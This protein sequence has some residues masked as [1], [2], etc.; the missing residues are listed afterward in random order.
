MY[1]ENLKY[2]KEHLWAR[3]EGGTAYIGITDFAQQQLGEIL[4]VEMPETGDEVACGESFGVIESSKTASEL[5]CPLSGEVVEINEELDDEPEYVNE[6]PY[7]AWIIKIEIKDAGEID[8]LMSA[9][10]YQGLLKK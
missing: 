6:S 3:I 10:E 7:D 1:P 4:F 2:N 5:I 9:S 8:K